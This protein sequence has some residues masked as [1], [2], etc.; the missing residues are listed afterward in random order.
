MKSDKFEVD[1]GVPQGSC[2]GPWFFSIYTSK[3]CEIV[4]N[5]LPTVH[6]FA[7]DT[8]LCLAFR[9]DGCASQEL[10]V[11]AMEGCMKDIR[12]WMIKDKAKVNDEKT[13]FILIGTR[14][15]LEKAQTD[16][17]VDG[18][19]MGQSI[20]LVHGLIKISL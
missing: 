11:A 3:L 19:S 16:S 7:D 4:S 12:D 10:A 18:H 5:H 14:P 8:E 9:P 15:Q 20:T 2:L 13:E 1:C 17:I 6:A